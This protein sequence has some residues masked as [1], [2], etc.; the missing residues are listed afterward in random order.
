M[1]ISNDMA[2]LIGFGCEAFFYGT[3]TSDYQQDLLTLTE[4]CYTVLFIVS[5]FLM[6]RHS[7]SRSG[8]NRPIFIISVFLY[9]LCAAHFALEF[10]HF[11]NVMVRTLYAASTVAQSRYDLAGHDGC[12]WLRKRDKCP[13]RRRHPYLGHGFHRWTYPHI[14]LLAALVQELLDHRLSESHVDWGAW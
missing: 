6:R 5:V 14:P 9:L 7:R 13:R 12:G 10:N 8:F 1:T 3:Y 2:A 4:G 11:Y